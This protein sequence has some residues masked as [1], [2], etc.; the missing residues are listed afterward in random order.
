MQ[1]LPEG[2]CVRHFQYGLGVVTQSDAQTFQTPEE[3]HTHTHTRAAAAS[4]VA[5]DNALMNRCGSRPPW[6]GVEL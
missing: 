4:L 3:G 2:R 5:C 1:S 6:S